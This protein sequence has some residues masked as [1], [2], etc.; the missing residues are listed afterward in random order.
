MEPVRMHSPTKGSS[1]QL[2]TDGYWHITFV[3]SFWNAIRR[4]QASVKQQK[5][6]DFLLFIT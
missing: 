3:F 2:R 6:D 4:I 1:Q 5:I